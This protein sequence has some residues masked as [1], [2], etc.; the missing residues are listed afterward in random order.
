[1]KSTVR[2]AKREWMIEKN[3]H[4]AMLIASVGKNQSFHPRTAP[5]VRR[6]FSGKNRK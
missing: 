4:R 1:L 2:Q 6:S 3:S 5:G